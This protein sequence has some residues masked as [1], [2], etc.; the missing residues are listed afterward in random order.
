MEID[1]CDQSISADALNEMQMP[2]EMKSGSWTREEAEE[3]I[4][5]ARA[6]V[7]SK[8]PNGMAPDEINAIIDEVRESSDL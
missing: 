8:Y 7:L 4:E 5:S 2:S 3:I 6:H 1:S